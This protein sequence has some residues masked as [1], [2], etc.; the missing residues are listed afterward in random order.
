MSYCKS[1]ADSVIDQLDQRYLFGNRNVLELCLVAFLARGHTLIEGP[2]GTGKTLTA[3]LLSRILSKSFKRIQFTSDMLPGDIIGA[4]IYSPASSEFNFVPGPIFAD[5]ILADEINR[6]PP[7]TQSALLEA[8]EERSVTVEGKSFSLPSDFFV[9]ATQNPQDFEGTFPLPEA[10]IDRFLFK[11]VVDHAEIE[12]EQ[13]VLTHILNG[14]LPPPFEKIQPV[15]FDRQQVEQ[16]VS[17]VTVDQSILRYIC[18][19]LE[20]HAQVQLSHLAVVSAVV[21]PSRAVLGLSRS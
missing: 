17:Q 18:E 21:L 14:T 11:I 5:F 2:P 7:R 9:I 6:T 3:R 20:R 15:E 19:I 13:E 12:A 1:L 16:E 4:H 8:M 10:Q